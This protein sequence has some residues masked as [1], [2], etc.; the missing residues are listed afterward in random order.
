MR[1]SII[2]CFVLFV[3]LSLV[4][5]QSVNGRDF[6]NLRYL[7]PDSARYK[8][9]YNIEMVRD[10]LNREDRLSTYW[11]LLIGDKCAKS[12]EYRTFMSDS[13]RMELVK[14]GATSSEILERRSAV[15]RGRIFREEILIDYP[16]IGSILFQES[17]T[18]TEMQRVHDMDSRQEWH[19][20][21]ETCDILGYECR[22]ATCHFR[23]RDYEAWYTMDIPFKYGPYYFRDLP[24][25]ILKLMDTNKEY[26]FNLIGLEKIENPFPLTLYDDTG[27]QDVSR[28]DF[29]FLKDYYAT[30]PASAIMMD[31]KIKMDLTPEDIQRINTHRPY[32]PI[33]RE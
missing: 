6:A 8:I 11:V 31:P 25:L 2:W 3:T 32:N 16:S 28:E 14:K 27:V 17:I 33:E 15:L 13:L 9:T 10:T 29:K 19:L 4:N 23:G 24:G 26:Q 21:D 12:E 22:K 20:V 5:A 30:D 18:P 1:K 7:M